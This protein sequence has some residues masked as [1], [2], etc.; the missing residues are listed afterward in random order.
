MMNEEEVVKPDR[1]GTMDKQVLSYR[2][3]SH[4]RKQTMRKVWEVE[5]WIER[6]GWVEEAEVIDYIV[7]RWDV[8]EATAHRYLEQVV[9]DFQRRGIVIKA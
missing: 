9:A 3:P 1:I 5:Q 7:R 8:S 4:R 2:G 6:K